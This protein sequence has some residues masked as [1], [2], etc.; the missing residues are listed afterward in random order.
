MPESSRPC[1][2]FFVL[3]H[4]FSRPISAARIYLVMAYPKLKTKQLKVTLAEIT[5]EL[6]ER[7][8]R[9]G[10][11]GTSVPDVAKSLIEE[12]LRRAGAK[13]DGAEQ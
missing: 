12:G 2:L 6:L 9:E 3:F 8:M 7:L 5:I 1:N 11:Y 10:N 13:A 4:A